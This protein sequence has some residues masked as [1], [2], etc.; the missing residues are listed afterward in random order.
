MQLV[1]SRRATGSELP[2]DLYKP[3]MVFLMSHILDISIQRS[4]NSDILYSQSAKV[5]RRLL[6]LESFSHKTV[7]DFAEKVMQKAG[8]T[9]EKR[10]SKLV[11]EDGACYDLSRLEGLDF[12]R[13]IFH[14]LPTLDGYIKSLSKRENDN[15]SVAF[16]PASVLTKYGGEKLPTCPASLTVDDPTFNLR[17]V[18]A[19]VASHLRQWLQQHKAD[20]DTCGILGDLIQ[21]YH[22]AAASVYSR[23][24]EASSTMLLTILE[25]WIACDESAVHICEL[26][27]DYDPGIPQCLL[28]SLVLPFKY[29][30]ERMFRAEKYLK[31]RKQGS[32]YA[33]PSIF[34][35][36]GLPHSFSVKYFNQCPEQQKVLEEIETRAAQER[37]KKAEELQQKKEEY[38]SLME[39]YN[40][41]KCD[42]HEVIVDHYN[43]FREQRHSP[44][45]KRHRYKSKADSLT[46]KI[47]EWPLPSDSLQARSTVFELRLPHFFGRWRDTTV[48]L[49][50][51]VLK[52]KYPTTG[53]L[54][55]SYP[56]DKYRGLSSF[57]TSFSSTQR[58]GLLSEKKPHEVTH[59]KEKE[60]SFTTESE[61]CLNNGLRFQYYDSKMGVFVGC[62]LITDEIPKELTYTLPAQSE[63]LKQFIYRPDTMPNGPS[64]NTVIASQSDC[65]S[66]MS[67]GEYKALCTIPLGCRIQWHN[68]L[69]QLSA[70]SVDF[71]KVETGLVILQT[72]YQAGPSNNDNNFL[73]VGHEVLSDEN[74]A[75]ALLASLH[76]A[77]GRFK[78]NWESSQAL[79]TFICLARRLLTLTSTDQMIEACLNYLSCARAIALRWVNILKDK[80][81]L[82]TDDGYRAELTSKAVEIALICVGTFNI[83]QKR[84]VNVFSIPRNVS[85]FV[86]CSIV[87][88]EGNH[89]LQKAPGSAI[90]LL[91]QRWQW[92]SYRGYPILAKHILAA[93]GGSL[94]DA[95]KR[96]WPAYQ[97]GDGWRV[98]SKQINHWLV[99]RTMPQGNSDS[100][101]IHFNLLTGE[102]LV[103]GLPLSRLPAKYEQHP[104]YR[105]LFGH[106]ALE[107][108]PTAVQGMQFSGKK[109]FAGYTLDFGISSLAETYK[110]YDILVRAVKCG[111]AF[112]LIPSRLLYGA[113]PHGFVENFVHWYNTADDYLEFRPTGSPW[114]S[115]PDNWRLARIGS[116]WNLTKSGNFL[117]SVNS[118]TAAEISHILRPL[119][120]PPRIHIIFHD[121]Q[122][123]V[124]VELPR[125]QLGFHLKSRSSFLQSRQFRGMAID[126]SQSIGTLIG[127]CS[128][129]VLKHEDGGRHF[130]LTEGP[131][132]YMKADNHVSV[133]I[134]KN[135][136]DAKAHLYSINGQIGELIDNGSLQSKLLLCYVHALTSFCLP[137]PLIRKTGTEQ[138]LTILD[139]AAVR[140]FDLLTAKNIEILSLIS[141]LTPRRSYYPAEER[142]MQS[143]KW[144]SELSFMSQHGGFFKSVASIFEQAERTKIFYPGSFIQPP[145]LNDVDSHLLERDCIRSS[146]FRVSGFGAEDHTVAYDAVYQP[147]DR[148]QTSERGSKAFI[149]SSIIYHGRTALHYK[150]S[151]GLAAYLWNY[152]LVVPRIFGPECPSIASKLAYDSVLLLD[153]S[154]FIS[155]HW[156]AL[157]RMLSQVPASVDKF[158]VMI[159]LSTLAFAKN[160]DFRIVQVLASFYTVPEMAQ[161]SA[162]C[163]DTFD[164]SQGHTASSNDLR[165]VFRSSYLPFHRCPE[166]SLPQ[167]SWESDKALKQRQ[168]RQFKDSQDRACNR[169]AEV[170]ESQWPCETPAAPA[171]D[172]GGV[173]LCQYA[174]VD[175]AMKGAR[176]KFRVWFENHRF[177][178]Y[179]CKIEST[180]SRQTIDPVPVPLLRIAKPAWNLQRKRG[181]IC[182]DDIMACTA[183]FMPSHG[184]ETLANLLS[185]SP[186]LNQTA[187][188]VQALIKHLEAQTSSSYESRYVE[189]LRQSLS[190]LQSLGKDYH[191]RL[192]K[193][194][195]RDIFVQHHRRC[196]ENSDKIYEAILSAVSPANASG[197]ERKISGVA[198]N[199]KQ[200][201]RLSPAF[202][203]GHLTRGRWQNMKSDWKQCIIHYALA[204]ANL[205]RAERLVSLLEKPVEL[206]KEILN[207]GHTN[208]D[209]FEYPESLLL[210]VE[211][212]IMIRE[213]QEQIAA[214]MR[215]PST[216]RN[217]VMQLN[218]GE[219]KS[220][221]IVPIV[222]T[223]LAD[224]SRLVR[225]I[226]AKPQSRQMSQMLVSK[227]GGLLNRRVYHMPFSRALQIG[228]DEANAIASLY[229]ECMQ[230]GGILLVQPEH[231][232]SFK[233]MGLECIIS[234]KG[235][236]GRSLLKTQQFFDKSSRDIV[237]ESDENFSV[238]FELVYTMGMQRP[239]EF[240]P[241]RWICIHQVLDLV[242]AF[243]PG[244]AKDFHRSIEVHDRWPGGFPR[245]RI[246][247]RD[248]QQRIFGLVAE[249]ICETGFSGFPIARQPEKVRLA[250]FKYITE[251]ELTESEIAEV[252]EQGSGKFWS[253]S[254]SSILLLLRG[255]IAGGVLP[256]AF[257][258][259]RWRVNYGLDATRQPPT[260]LAVPYRAKD[261]PTPRSE[262]SHPDV[263]I[264]LTSLS[265]YYGGL[266][267]DDM[268]VTFAHLMKSDQAEI[269]YQ[270][271][272]KDAPDLPSAFCQLVGINLKDQFQCIDQVFPSLRHAK[273]VI[274]YF[275]AHIV[276]PKEMKEYPHKLS[277]SGWDI[278]QIKTHPTTG[279]SGTNDSR[280]TLPLSVEHLDLQEQKHTNALVLEY[281]LQRENS[282]ALMR[283]RS[284][285][286]SSDTEVLLD[287]VVKMD[288]PA[289]VILDV[290][291]QILE[292][293]NL[294]VARAWLKMMP[295]SGQ[296]QAV[297]FFDDSDELSVLDRRGHI[298]PLQTSSFAKQLDL[299]FVFLDEAHTRGTDLKLPDYYRAAVTLGANLTKDR[300][301]QACMR[302]R[303]LGKGQSVVFCVPEEIYTKILTRRLER[304]GASIDVSDV[305]SWAVS[306]TCIDMRRNIPL[307]AVQ[308]QRYERQRALWAE[309]QTNGEIQ[310][311]CDQAERFLEDESQTLEARYRPISQTGVAP[312][313]QVSENKNLNLIMERCR[314]FDN[315]NLNSA[316]LQEEQERELSPENE[317]ERQVQRPP[318]AQAAK[319]S[320]HPDL[321]NF[322]SAGKVIAN[323]KAYIPAFDI[324][325]NTSAAKYLDVSQFPNDLLVSTDF[326][327]TVQISGKSF[328]S[329]TYQ[330][331]V[332]WVLTLASET[333]HRVKRMMIISPFE[334]EQ[335]IPTVKESK[336]VT[337]HLYAPRH[338]LG[339]RSLD[340]LDL[341]T[342][343]ERP[344]GWEL[345]RQL[346]LQLNVFSGQLFLGS[347]KEYVEMCQF[348]GLA[349]EK[350][351]DGA[352]VAADGFVMDDGLGEGGRISTFADSPVKFL[353]VFLTKI[354]RNCEEISKTHMG[355]ILDGSLLR[356]EDFGEVDRELDA[357]TMETKTGDD[358][359]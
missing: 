63:S 143:V 98:V 139:S 348:L 167:S 17:A 289:Q 305:L 186:C 112:E 345:S 353:K 343:P 316:V 141:D 263:V 107:V 213:V 252:E 298:E 134:S 11:R 261:N 33:S 95:I 258:Q 189:D 283:S 295:D 104:T 300:L 297:V 124:E 109:E 170:L 36:F 286:S 230:N 76:E 173:A 179:L 156:N 100:L 340:Q 347:F 138:A 222:A 201:P 246:L 82:A 251:P 123:S 313:S 195:L 215:D 41:S 227:L 318:P 219:G 12:G 357:E 310:M 320:V 199:I 52:A 25:L 64:P 78:E 282:V 185:S 192:S 211:T 50:L 217:A 150:V 45:C 292:L 49:L 338:N 158:R 285:A 350:A 314:E 187:P 153:Y 238:K 48:F 29:Q 204:L 113:F 255:L 117:I 250:V 244:V 190:S 259:K 352:V 129:L 304:N 160:A 271:W 315:L 293:S 2:E 74:F 327:S 131:I 159:W 346:V 194:D 5:A 331:P 349:W 216:S 180:L 148:D 122:S 341:Y 299:C 120:D 108:M 60:I 27:K 69:L 242:R 240:S 317:Q 14:C 247:Q 7:L 71:K 359:N 72:I 200:W 97:A 168:K 115:S 181:F 212:G 8:T 154:E 13:D 248:A 1:F 161:V 28:Q 92:L 303:K 307:W 24:P 59:R 218:M 249:R 149:I 42:Y 37:E 38:K 80:A 196:K 144:L 319:H 102:L 210:E 235:S 203:L 191:L 267:N 290:G 176:S 135:Y 193:D 207:P 336:Y 302:M 237:D 311:S 58:I 291:A 202:F 356:R 273:S 354:R 296:Q 114:T 84:L 15:N 172:D 265:Y 47:H 67:L 157:H 142:T 106:A 241:E 324:L 125:L 257:G 31:S 133:S 268:F 145:P 334:A 54:R 182:I 358:K 279:F 65:P 253:T 77:L 301:V 337:L 243:V 208:W 9:I 330:R 344:D 128:K 171:H 266:E 276:F 333:E 40:R 66:H 278:G 86:Q 221:V 342:I 183:P 62:F 326:A 269:E 309:T 281:L 184:Q 270:I 51:D 198:E 105:T 30:M 146:A 140:S 254:T 220:S 46:I 110:E 96:S 308:G 264:V 35:D 10:W 56:L 236:V 6:K 111:Q 188:R 101:S 132:S 16:E 325:R 53:K 85:D 21:N 34:R 166:A 126:P 163:I 152:L 43:D 228:Q 260:K 83:D 339:Y 355:T 155:K 4:L 234:G 118:D 151:A 136:A 89:T 178:D 284:E 329:D 164:L 32:R 165:D 232:L 262:F 335:L 174:D 87:I 175:E 229:R 162:P 116:R 288:P 3:F 79:S 323:S 205:Q 226:V 68:I 287:M 127:L 224:G 233:L 328:I 70:P 214:Q 280:K 26:L 121:T 272:V 209:P 130:I 169:F 22:T 57:F 19:W 39:L 225:V 119:E 256:F 239:V 61:V 91:H 55:A 245:T 294:E 137:D 275:L 94:D 231:L 90:A 23:N 88:Q 332:H 274:D 351:G 306:E 93:G 223:A 277:A 321:V 322:V 20:P 99:S 18:E 44:M 206:V 197:Q 81:H 147:R 312:P 73:R 75:K 103:N 177:Y